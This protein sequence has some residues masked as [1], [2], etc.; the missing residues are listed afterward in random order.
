MPIG[1]HSPDAVEDPAGRV[2]RQ[3]EIYGGPVE[4]P[5]LLPPPE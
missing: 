1:V 3:P 4:P 5:E 2:T